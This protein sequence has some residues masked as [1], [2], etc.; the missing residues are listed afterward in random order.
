MWGGKRKRRNL[1]I[2][3]IRHRDRAL[4]QFSR[5]KSNSYC[6]LSWAENLGELES[7][8][9]IFL[10]LHIREFSNSQIIVKIK[11]SVYESCAVLSHLSHVLLFVTLWTVA[12][13]APL[14][15][16]FS[17]QEYWSGWPC[18]PP[19]DLPHPGTEPVSLICPALTG[20]FFTVSTTWEAHV[21][22]LFQITKAFK[23]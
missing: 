9:L 6:L 21:W 13:Q 22:K 16:E 10:H 18:P 15:M 23:I 4:S 7:P 14:S 8:N 19:G 3:V 11:L 17:R 12:C 1:T 20:G 5:N 2:S